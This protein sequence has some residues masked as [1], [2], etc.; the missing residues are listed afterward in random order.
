M[1]DVHS[2]R[3]REP[4]QREPLEEGAGVRF[5]RRFGYPTGLEPHERVFLVLEPVYRLAKLVLNGNPVAGLTDRNAA[6]EWDVTDRLEERNEIAA[7]IEFGPSSPVGFESRDVGDILG[8]VRL[9]IRF[10]A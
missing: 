1:P 3:L 9:E 4:W 6:L 8:K 2:I 7:D 5:R 10:G